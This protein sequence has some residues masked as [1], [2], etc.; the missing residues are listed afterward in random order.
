MK[1]R[2]RYSPVF[3]EAYQ[4]L[5]KS[6][7]WERSRLEEYQWLE[8]KKLLNYAYNNTVYYQKKF[9]EYGII[10]DGI[11]DFD[12]FSKKV[13]VLTKDDVRNNLEDLIALPKQK[14]EYVS[15]GGSTG[16]PLGFFLEKGVTYQKTL[17]FEWRQFNEGGYFFGD[18]VAVL[19]GRVLKDCFF[20][21]DRKQRRLFLSTFD[22]TEE[23]M[24]KYV[25]LINRY[26]PKHIRAYPSA[27]EMLAKLIIHYYPGFNEDKSILSLFTSS[28]DLSNH[29]REVFS[30]ALRL[31]VFDKYGNNEQCGM[32][33]QCKEGKYHEYM[34]FAYSEFLDESNNRVKEG[35]AKLI[36]TSFVN[37]ALPFI[38]YDTGDVVELDGNGEC[39]CGMEH[40]LIKRINGR[41]KRN[42]QVVGRDGNLISLTA[43]NSHSDIFDN[44]YRIQY[45]QNEKG[46]VTL[47]IVPKQSYTSKDRNRIYEELNGKLKE[48][49]EL[50]VTEVNNVQLTKSGKYKLLVQNLDLMDFSS[51]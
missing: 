16:I 2:R 15:T 8:I 38:R 28:E 45:L 43:L 46:K 34:E 26:R 33:G 24:H 23:N 39:F 22:M 27:A 25:D 4:F 50:T 36:S 10:P 40:R 49:L 44:V 6:K 3:W 31:I 7:L 14:L 20:A 5:Q 21:I 9:S 32:I 12:D 51:D 19:R 35:K 1:L 41:W 37:Y 29:Q 13:P 17:A 30:K 48:R 42:Y 11:K 47:N 18:K